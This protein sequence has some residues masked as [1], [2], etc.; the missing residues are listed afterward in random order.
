MHAA[1]TTVQPGIPT[2]SLFL[3]QHIHV[4]A[5]SS[6]DIIAS[7]GLYNSLLRTPY[8][9]LCNTHKFATTQYMWSTQ[10]SVRLWG[11]VPTMPASHAGVSC[12]DCSTGE[13]L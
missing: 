5:N 3:Q 6:C 10:A 9:S 13:S 12:C 2:R 11:S 7:H 4:H 8:L 1:M